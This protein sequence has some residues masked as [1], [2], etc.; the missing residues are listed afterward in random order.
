MKV[1]SILIVHP[2]DALACNLILAPENEDENVTF[3]VEPI[4][5]VELS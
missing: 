1:V 5:V 3:D 2:A 4:S